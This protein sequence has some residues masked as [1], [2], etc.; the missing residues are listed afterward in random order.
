LTTISWGTLILPSIQIL[1]RKN[2][3]NIAFD[4]GMLSKGALHT[5]RGRYFWGIIKMELLFLLLF[6]TCWIGF[7]ALMSFLGGWHQL[8]SR[9]RASSGIEGRK[10]RF[11]SMQLGYS[12]GY[13]HCIF[14]TVGR[15][16]VHLSIFFLFRPFNPP[17]FIPWSVVE[18]VRHTK[19][20]FLPLYTDLRI[21]GLE[22]RMRFSRR[23]GMELM[24]FFNAKDLAI[25]IQPR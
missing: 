5:I 8:A 15:S 11:A 12:A 24:E 6:P 16:G 4:T 3:P 14:I 20:L 21:K 19:F 10:F 9:F 25:P 22:K 7:G 13:D 23:V 1:A 18:E 17:L 2:K